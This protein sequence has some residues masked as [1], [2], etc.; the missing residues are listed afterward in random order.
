VTFGDIWRRS[1][2]AIWRIDL[3]TRVGSERVDSV[4]YPMGFKTC[5]LRDTSSEALG[6]PE[7]SVGKV[8]GNLHDAH[9]SLRR[10]CEVNQWSVRLGSLTGIDEVA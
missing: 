1:V 4:L 2:I 8:R 7:G 6:G 10:C 3:V 5:K 9:S